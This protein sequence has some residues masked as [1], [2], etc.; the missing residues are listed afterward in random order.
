MAVRRDGDRLV[1]DRAVVAATGNNADARGTAT[2]T[3]PIGL[4]RPHD[5]VLSRTPSDGAPPVLVG[6]ARW[7]GPRVRLLLH[8]PGAEPGVPAIDAELTVEGFSEPGLQPGKRTFVLPRNVH[9]VAEHGN[10]RNGTA[11]S[12][13]VTGHASYPP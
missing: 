4:V 1:L 6:S 13:R 3:V 2:C 10:Q 9:L 8:T 7:T 12:E 11:P 5:I